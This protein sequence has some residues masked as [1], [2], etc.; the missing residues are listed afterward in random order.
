MRPQLLRAIYYV[1]MDHFVTIPNELTADLAYHGIKIFQVPFNSIERFL[2]PKDLSPKSCLILCD[3]PSLATAF[4]EAGYYVVAVSHDGN[5]GLAFPGLEYAVEDFTEIEW[6]YF[7]KYWQRYAGVPW[8]ITDTERCRIREMCPDDLNELY[9]MYSDKRICKYTDDL[10]EDRMTELNYIKDY[11]KHMYHF[12]GFGTWIIE[13]RFSGKMIGRAGFNY[14]PGF[15]DPELGFVI[16]P[17]LWRHG[18]ALEVCSALIEYGKRE[19]GFTR[20]HAFVKPENTASVC[21][22]NKLGFR[23]CGRYTIN[24][25][26]HDRCVLDL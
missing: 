18:Y 12:Y 6:F 3:I 21:L 19:F 22:L 8:H 14:R 4:L 11:V 13:D 26:L 9:D 5:R 15:D 23:T 2:P 10:F 16:A 17:A 25:K 7:V 20:I 24:E 1:T